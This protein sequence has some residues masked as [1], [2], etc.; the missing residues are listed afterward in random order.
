MSWGSLSLRMQVTLLIMVLDVLAALA[1]GFAVPAQINKEARASYL[2]E[3]EALTALAS[4]AVLGGTGAK[5]VGPQAAEVLRQLETFDTGTQ[6][7][8][9]GYDS[10]ASSVTVAD[11]GTSAAPWAGRVGAGEYPLPKSNVG[12]VTTERGVGVVVAC[13]IPA[14][15]AAV[16]AVFS[17]AR[18]VG[19]QALAFRVAVGIVAFSIILGVLAALALAW[20]LAS[21][22]SKMT[23]MAKSVASG[24]GGVTG[25]VVEGANAEVRAMAGSVND[26]LSNMRRLVTQMVSLTGRLGT[27]AKGLLDASNDQEH[28]TSQQSAYAQQIAATFEELSRTAEKISQATETVEY[29]AVRTA[30]AVDDARKV[31][32]EVVSGISNVRRE[33]KEVAEAISRLNADLQQVSRIAQVINQVA[34]RSDLLAL[35]AA[36]EGTKAGDV[37]RGFS[38]VAVEMRKLAESVA[39]SARDIGRLV[40]AVKVSGDHAVNKAREGVQASDRGVQVAEKAQGSFT[41]ISEFAKNTKEAA[42]QIAVATRQQKE[43]A[44]QA[45]QGARNVADLVKRGV[46]ATGRTTRIAGD[47]QSA[48]AALGE[49]TSQFRAGPQGP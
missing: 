18:L 38:L 3:A 6:A 36:L 25:V 5:A 40:E 23:A 17:G 46:D 20:I 26:M 1:M 8:V 27:A 39:G 34:D 47:L 43:S 12:C 42:Q 44:E 13:V 30:E 29:A 15:G 24:E 37:G 41:Q 31:V 45:V 7:A 9:L 11:D 21:P 33:S 19:T 16:V 48:V 2:V 28:V 4:K 10:T 49:V 14:S 32:T 22:V 35:N